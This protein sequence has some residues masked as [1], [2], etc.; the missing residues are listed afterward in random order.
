M[1]VPLHH[2]GPT[3]T[4]M[5]MVAVA[6]A[7]TALAA[8]RAGKCRA[9]IAP[10]LLVAP[11]SVGTTQQAVRI[12]VAATVTTKICLVG[13]FPEIVDR[14]LPALPLVVVVAVLAGRKEDECACPL[15]K[16][17]LMISTITSSLDLVQSMHTRLREKARQ[18]TT[19]TKASTPRYLLWHVFAKA[20]LSKTIIQKSCLKS[21]ASW[22]T[23][24]CGKHPTTRS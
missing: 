5:T 3:R 16:L 11:G 2:G 19:P 14:R 8:H 18:E 22:R 6:A 4:A 13:G 12:P 15:K 23:K 17:I 24:R 9:E 7:A 20:G 10:A 21:F 1:E